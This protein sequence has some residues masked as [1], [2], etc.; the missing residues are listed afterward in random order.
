MQ[1]LGEAMELTEPMLAVAR[2]GNDGQALTAGKPLASAHGQ[3]V[4]EYVMTIRPVP[5]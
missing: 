5:I 2:Y 4:T 3:T 1:P